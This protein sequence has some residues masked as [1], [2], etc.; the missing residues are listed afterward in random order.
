MHMALWDVGRGLLMRPWA[1]NKTMERGKSD[2]FLN[3]I[4]KD[5]TGESD[6]K[7]V[8]T[9]EQ[10]TRKNRVSMA[11]LLYKP[12]VTAPI[13][14]PTK[15]ESMCELATA[16]NFTLDEADIKAQVV[17]TWFRQPS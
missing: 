5:A 6:K 10:L 9:V 17:S 4:V 15:V 12:G 8:S 14:G 3:L 13:F 2:K 1:Q 11:W 16:V 7:I